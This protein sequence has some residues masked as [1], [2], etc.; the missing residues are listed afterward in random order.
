MSGAFVFFI[1]FL[2]C[3]V[4]YCMRARDA[5]DFAIVVAS[6]QIPLGVLKNRV[7]KNYS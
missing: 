6:I 4:V 3:G 1:P 5:L 7:M 2:F